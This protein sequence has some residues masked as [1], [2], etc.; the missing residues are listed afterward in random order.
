M[1]TAYIEVKRS[2]HSDA[3][4]FWGRKKIDSSMVYGNIVYRY[5]VFEWQK[6]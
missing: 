6:K 3:S 2:D 1:V 4:I 5:E